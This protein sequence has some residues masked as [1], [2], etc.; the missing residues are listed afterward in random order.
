MVQKACN[1]VCLTDDKQ[2]W[3]VLRTSYKQQ[4]FLSKAVIIKAC[5]RESWS[6]HVTSKKKLILHR[7]KNNTSDSLSKEVVQLS[8]F[9][10]VI[11]SKYVQKFQGRVPA[12]QS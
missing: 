11:Y 6:K 10:I 2:T 7:W 5:I 12:L 9:I 4:R 8:G 3:S 1:H